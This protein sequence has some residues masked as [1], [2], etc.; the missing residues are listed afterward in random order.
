MEDNDSG[1][2]HDSGFSYD[3]YYHDSSISND[4]HGYDYNNGTHNYSYDDH[5]HVIADDSTYDYPIMFQ[6]S[7]FYNSRNKQTCCQYI[8]TLFTNLVRKFY[9]KKI[10]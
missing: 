9:F 8:T 10:N 6:R 7:P 2:S 1:T 5:M 4:D 3:S